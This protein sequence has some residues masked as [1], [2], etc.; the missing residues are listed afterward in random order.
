MDRPFGKRSKKS[1]KPSQHIILG[2]PTNIAAGPLG[3]RA[4]LD[5]EP[6]GEKGC[7]HHDFKTDRSDPTE[8]LD[9]KNPRASR[10]VFFDKERD[11]QGD[12]VQEAST[13]GAVIGSEQGN[14]LTSERL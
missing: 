14:G 10:I 3:F 4:E 8:T 12:P 13:S 5:I 7:P 1:L 2:I 11:G 9:E 6:K